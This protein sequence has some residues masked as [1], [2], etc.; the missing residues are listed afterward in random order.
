MIV[1]ISTA[2]FHILCMQQPENDLLTINGDTG[3][4]FNLL[5]LDK[6]SQI[7]EIIAEKS[8]LAIE[9]FKKNE[10]KK[11]LNHLAM[12]DV[13]QDIKTTNNG[14]SAKRRA[15]KGLTLTDEFVLNL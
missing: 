6:Q 14:K 13:K 4:I 5:S 11:I 2:N 12:N 9:T 10:A 3:D 8:S 1:K 15:R 7:K